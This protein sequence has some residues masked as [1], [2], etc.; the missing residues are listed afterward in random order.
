MKNKDYLCGALKNI[1]LNKG[2][3]SL[4]RKSLKTNILSYS[5]NIKKKLKTK[6]I[7]N[8][9][10][11]ILDTL[12]SMLNR[13]NKIYKTYFIN[14]S[15]IKL[16]TDEYT[17]RTKIIKSIKDFISINLLHNNKNIN[18]D[19]ILLEVIYYF[20]LIIIQNKKFKFLSSLEKIGLG[21]LIL[22]LKFNKLQDKYLIKKYKSIFNDKYMTLEE[23]NKIEILSLK[24]INYY[25]IQPN[26][27]HYITFL[28]KNIFINDQFKNMNYIYKL[29][30]A[31]LKNIMCF[32]NNY[33]KIHPFNLSCFIIKNCFEQN[34]IEGFQ[35]TIID[36]FDINMRLFRAAYEDFLKNNNSQMKIYNLFEKQKKEENIKINNNSKIFSNTVSKYFKRD[37]KN[38]KK[39]N[40]IINP[41]NNTYYK[42]YL[43]NYLSTNK[44]NS[45]K[46]NNKGVDYNHQYQKTL[47]NRD[48][49]LTK[50]NSLK[51]NDELF[52]INFSI[53]NNKMN[54]SIESPKRSGISINYRYKRKNQPIIA[55]LKYKNAFYNLL[56]KEENN[57]KIEKIEIKKND[58]IS[59]T[60]TNIKKEN[61]N[62]ERIDINN[63]KKININRTISENNNNN[64]E[65]KN[66]TENKIEKENEKESNDRENKC[67]KINT[68][69]ND[70]NENSYRK[71]FLCYNY[72]HTFRN[73]IRNY[74][75]NLNLNNSSNKNVKLTNDENIVEK[76]KEGTSV[77][78]PYSEKN[79]IYKC[80]NRNNNNID[81]SNLKSTINQSESSISYFKEK[82]IGIKKAYKVH[83]RNF[84]KQKNSFLLN[85]SNYGNNQ[86]L[87]K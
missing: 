55:Q 32:S 82:N 84:Y 85:M 86:T 23:I 49:K 54:Y 34:K 2:H 33:I 30:I 43:N 12:N 38:N 83:I 73:N 25:I 79:K 68:E 72:K 6:T 20:D 74:L 63:C 24:L 65:N 66:K 52:G 31:I 61:I 19:N 78:K 44:Y 64:K 14:L 29:I 53:N 71:N 35:K 59:N 21:A 9:E 76:K 80:I 7:L 1:N 57:I 27:I 17:K 39:I 67:K 60:N 10:I 41:M 69:R 3:I 11:N 40:V 37:I 16:D 26:P 62:K 77:I 48:G 36:F 70:G 28:F 42:K 8:N 51:S 75:I 22:V 47:D 56:K 81:D 5:I 87:L 58:V 18:R 50:K 13:T 45:S 15:N 46:P 4:K